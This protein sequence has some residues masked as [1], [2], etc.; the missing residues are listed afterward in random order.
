MLASG[1]V[2][3]FLDRE[4]RLRGALQKLVNS[5]LA[6]KVESALSLAAGPANDVR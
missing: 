2:R 4:T 1:D 3:A 5:E 6:R